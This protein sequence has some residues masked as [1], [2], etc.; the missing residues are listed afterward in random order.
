MQ[1]NTLHNLS[2]NQFR[3]IFSD[4]PNVGMGDDFYIIDVS[5]SDRNRALAHPCRIDGFMVIYCL[6]G[7]VKLNVNLHEYDLKPGML[8]LNYPGNIIRVNELVDSDNE[9]LRYICVVMSRDFVGNLMVDVNKIFTQNLSLMDTPSIE[10]DDTQKEILREH[11]ALMVSILQNGSTFRLESVRAVLSSIFYQLAGVWSEYF[12]KRDAGEVSEITSRSRMIFEQF[13]KL[14]TEYHT[15][16]RNVGFYADK[17]YMTPKYLS[18]VI[19]N[20][21]GRSAPEWIDAYVILEAKNLLKYSGLAIKEIVY[22]LNFPSQSVFYKFF[23][24]H[25]GMTPS[26]YKNS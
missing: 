20:V 21:S 4:A 15:Q 14:V 5:I 12:S 16:Y 18:R 3:N 23:K 19:K 9:Q 25:T 7:H 13:I 17:L 24:A 11:I 2:I 22:Q 1:N 8:Y 10:L 6:S 26:E